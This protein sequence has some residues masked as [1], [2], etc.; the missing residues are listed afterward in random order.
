MESIKSERGNIYL[1][2]L[3]ICVLIILYFSW[4]DI[5]DGQARVNFK[6]Y[7]SIDPHD[8]VERNL[9]KPLVAK[10]IEE[11]KAIA[12][13]SSL[14]V[15]SIRNEPES[16]ALNDLEDKLSRIREAKKVEKSAWLDWERA[17][18]AAKWEGY[19]QTCGATK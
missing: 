2:V 12:S 4:S 7:F 5:K 18:S 19:V 1:P 11:L 9:V 3:V 8:V 14:V 6:T 13:K 17:C 15:E 10:K 16:L